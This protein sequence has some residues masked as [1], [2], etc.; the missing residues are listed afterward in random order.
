MD[1]IILKTHDENE[2]AGIISRLQKLEKRIFGIT[3]EDMAHAQCANCGTK[4]AYFVMGK[5]ICSN[6]P[7]CHP[8]PKVHDILAEDD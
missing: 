5:P 6:Y 4:A 1:V 2:M 3:E 7:K 8:Y